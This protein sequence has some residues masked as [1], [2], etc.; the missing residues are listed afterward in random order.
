MVKLARRMREGGG[1]S[2]K[3]QQTQG[4]YTTQKTR[5]PNCTGPHTKRGEIALSSLCKQAIVKFISS[6]SHSIRCKP[7]DIEPLSWGGFDST[8]RGSI[9]GLK[10]KTIGK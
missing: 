9:Q 6:D 10:D 1:E 8:T 2:Q 4:Q 7:S 3:E 5:E